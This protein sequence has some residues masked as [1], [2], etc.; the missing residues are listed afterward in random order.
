MTLNKTLLCLLTS[1][2]LSTAALAGP[3]EGQGIYDNFCVVCHG[4]LGEGETMGKPLVDNNARALSDAA[5]IDVISKGR[6][7]TGMAAYG[8]ALSEVEIRDVAGYIRVLQGGTG[9]A[10]E[11][12][13]SS[14][15]DDPQVA[16]GQELFS[17]KAGCADCHTLSGSGGSV[18]P[19]LDGVAARLDEAQ[20]REAL[21]APSRSIVSGYGVKI[22]ETNDGQIIK[23]RYRNDSEQAIQM[24]SEDGKR[25]LTQFKRNLKSISDSDESLMPEVFATLSVDEQEALLAYLRAVGK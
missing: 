11:D 2:L 18:G 15:L 10:D 17:G 20:L 12:A 14:A 3:G 25:W 6:P 23:G 7:G 19:A 1:G 13:G 4:G 9:L 22:L 24:L 21:E 16:M 8:G 5:L